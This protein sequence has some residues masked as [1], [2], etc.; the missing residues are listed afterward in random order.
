MPSGASNRRTGPPPTERVE[1]PEPPPSEGS[2]DDDDDEEDAGS[3][4]RNT[5]FPQPGSIGAAQEPRRRVRRIPT[6][7]QTEALRALLAEVGPWI[8]SVFAIY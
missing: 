7:A 8:F 5:S 4:E 2:Y 1:S 3:T 6:P